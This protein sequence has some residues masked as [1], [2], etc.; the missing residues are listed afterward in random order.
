MCSCPKHIP[1]QAPSALLASAETLSWSRPACSLPCSMLQHMQA[2]LAGCLIIT[3]P[4]LLLF[5]PLS[6]AGAGS[7]GH[8]AEIKAAGH[9]SI[10]QEL[11]ARTLATHLCMQLACLTAPPH[12]F[13]R[14]LWFCL[15]RAQ[16][17]VA[18]TSHETCHHTVG[19][20]QQQHSHKAG[21]IKLA[22]IRLNLFSDQAA[23]MP[24]PALASCTKRGGCPGV[25]RGSFLPIAED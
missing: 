5:W 13:P 12:C 23:W 21:N 15:S 16:S 8:G 22:A 9:D 18:S 2:M 10:L 24:E 17:P 25:Q 3:R 19:R 20:L 4:Y 14:S 1:V 6:T 7:D 11:S